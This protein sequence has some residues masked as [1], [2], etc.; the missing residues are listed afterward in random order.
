MLAAIYVYYLSAVDR[1]S[2]LALNVVEVD[3]QLRFINLYSILG[4]VGLAMWVPSFLGRVFKPR[5]RPGVTSAGHRPAQQRARASVSGYDPG[6]DPGFGPDRERN[7]D[8]GAVA[9]GQSR[10]DPFGRAPTRPEF[11]TQASPWREEIM[12]QLRRFDGGP[13]ARIVTDDAMGVP[14]VLV[15]ENMAPR[16]CED[17]ITTLGQ[18]LTWI[19]LPPRVRIRFENCPEGPAPRHH[20]VGKALG[21][22]IDPG[23]FK[24]VSNAN[25]VD[26]MF[27]NPDPRWREQW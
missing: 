6:Y 1:Q 23:V 17:A 19:P 4:I 12:N 10:S 13:G 11:A 18:L 16:H 21:S 7:T 3:T 26:V 27:L 15:L 2:V 22:V 20:L 24:A 8:Y 25:Q 14:L 5:Q 9:G